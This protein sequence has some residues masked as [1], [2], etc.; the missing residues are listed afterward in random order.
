METCIQM[1]KYYLQSYS[2]MLALHTQTDGKKNTGQITSKKCLLRKTS[3]TRT[4]SRQYEVQRTHR[5]KHYSV[6]QRILQ[7][8]FFYLLLFFPFAPQLSLSKDQAC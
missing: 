2:L 8:F 5:A 7:Y 6:T 1:S 4:Q 3:I